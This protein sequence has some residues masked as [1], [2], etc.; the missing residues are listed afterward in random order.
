[1][2][3]YCHGYIADKE[4]GD[5]GFGYDCMFCPLE[6]DGKTFSEISADEKNAISHR[7][8][9]LQEFVTKIREIQGEDK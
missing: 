4:A 1:M 2:E 8:R 6:Y 9:A 5:G 3:G 7:G